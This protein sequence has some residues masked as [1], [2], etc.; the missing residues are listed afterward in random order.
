[1]LFTLL[2]V[3]FTSRLFPFYSRHAPSRSTHFAPLPSVFQGSNENDVVGLVTERSFLNYCI[4]PKCAPGDMTCLR[5]SYGVFACQRETACRPHAAAPVCLPVADFACPFPHM[6]CGRR[7]SGLPAGRERRAVPVSRTMG[8]RLGVCRSQ[9]R[10]SVKS[11]YLACCTNGM[12][13]CLR[14]SIRCA[15]CYDKGSTLKPL[16]STCRRRNY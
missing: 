7:S 4:H 12:M 9:S 14:N 8:G 11:W 15:P 2:P 3:L 13:T 10:F 6:V 16:C 5:D 1:M